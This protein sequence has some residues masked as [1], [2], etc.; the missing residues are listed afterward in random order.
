MTEE[1]ALQNSSEDEK[2]SEMLEALIMAAPVM[3]K[4]FPL[5]CMIGITDKNN[6][7]LTYLPSKEVNLGNVVGTKVPQGIRCTRR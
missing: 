2:K 3:Q 7:Y 1:R 5:D 6:T 4:L